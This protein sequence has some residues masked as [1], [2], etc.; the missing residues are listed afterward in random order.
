[1]KLSIPVD[2]LRS[3]C[4]KC[5]V[6]GLLE[7]ETNMGRMHMEITKTNIILVEAAI[8]N[9][10]NFSELVNAN[11]KKPSAVD[12]LVRKVAVPIFW[13]TLDSAFTLFPCSLTS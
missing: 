7:N 4:F 11:V 12:K 6:L 5:L 2:I 1:M 9:S 10:I 8:P 3:K 13:I